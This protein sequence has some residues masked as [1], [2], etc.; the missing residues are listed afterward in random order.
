VIHAVMKAA[1]FASAGLAIDM[2]STRRWD[3]MGG[4][5]D[6][7]P[8]FA[9]ATLVPAL[10]LAGIPPLAGFIGKVAVFGSLLDAGAWVPVGALL[11]A[12]LAILAAMARVWLSA[13]GGDPAETIETAQAIEAAETPAAPPAIDGRKLGLVVV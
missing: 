11:L 5:I 13:F 7:S 6:R 2:T 1:L 8:L 9:A 12:S 3:Q 10:S 4:L